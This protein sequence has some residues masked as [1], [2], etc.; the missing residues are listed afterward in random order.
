MPYPL[1]ATT[2]LFG[3]SPADR[4]QL[5][6]EVVWTSGRIDR[7]DIYRKL[8]VAEIRYWR[9]G[10]IEPYGLRGDR[11]VQIA[12]SEVLP[13]L[14]LDLLTAFLDRPTTSEAIRGYRERL[15]AGGPAD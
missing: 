1:A 6:I 3:D 13:G 11:Y 14:D 12:A 2:R 10:R 9:Q 5:A 15:R 4:P 8:G 7:L